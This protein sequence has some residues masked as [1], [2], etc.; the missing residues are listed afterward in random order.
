MST[1]LVEIAVFSF[2]N[3][4]VKKKKK[5]QKFTKILPSSSSSKFLNIPLVFFLKIFSKISFISPSEFSPKFFT[6]S[7]LLLPQKF[8]S[9]FP[10]THRLLHLKFLLNFTKNLWL[11]S[12]F[13]LIKTF[14]CKFWNNKKNDTSYLSKERWMHP[15]NY[16]WEN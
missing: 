14:T 16:H 13:D 3:N 1:K 4:S 9:K 12:R 5:N 7:H 15:S 2:F 6:K 11:S 10:Q 8:P